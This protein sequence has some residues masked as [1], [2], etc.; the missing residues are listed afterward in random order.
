MVGYAISDRLE[1]S[2][3]I[4][5][6]FKETEAGGI[7]NNSSGLGDIYLKTRYAA[8]PWKKD[9]C[10][11]TFTGALRLGTGDY[12]AATPTLGDGSTDLG[13]GF[14]HSTKW[15]NKL[16]GH[17]KANWW[18]NGVTSGGI[19]AGDQ[20]KVIVKGD[21]KV[22]K[23]IM[24]FLTYVFFNQGKKQ[25]AGGIHVTNSEKVRHYVVIGG[26]YKPI[27]G[28]FVRPKV[29][30]PIGGKGSKNFDFKPMLDFWYVF[31]GKCCSP[32]K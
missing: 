2:Y 32:K 24:P 10:G 31:E 19:N 20:L 15:M 30:I 4:P 8:I 22:N 23:Q 11:L 12:A 29:S 28:M 18:I 9:Q 17:L 7:T 3:H 25:T 14:I 16:R 6:P 27:K 21:Y 1:A 5:I 26:V 13:L